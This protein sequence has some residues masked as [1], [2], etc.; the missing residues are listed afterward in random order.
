MVFGLTF[1]LELLVFLKIAEPS[2]LTATELADSGPN[3]YRLTFFK[4]NKYVLGPVI[5]TTDAGGKVLDRVV[6]QVNSAGKLRLEHLEEQVP[7]CDKPQVVSAE[8]Q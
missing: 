6:I 8:P 4:G 3:H 2:S 7:E 5:E 1:N